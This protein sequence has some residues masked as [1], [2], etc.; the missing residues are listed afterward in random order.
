MI[1]YDCILSCPSSPKNKFY[2][3]YKRKD[4]IGSVWVSHGVDD[5]L[6]REASV[7]EFIYGKREEGAATVWAKVQALFST[8]TPPAAPVAGDHFGQARIPILRR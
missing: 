7:L 2:S 6:E 5:V 3:T 8:L 4:Y 1:E